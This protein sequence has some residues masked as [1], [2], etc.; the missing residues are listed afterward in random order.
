MRQ[1]ILKIRIAAPAVDGKANQELI[2]F[3]GKELGVPAKYI[4]LERGKTARE[5]S[6]RIEGIESKE[7]LSRL[8]GCGVG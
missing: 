3:L 2:R 6:L 1:E 8:P 5:K 7:V 4:R